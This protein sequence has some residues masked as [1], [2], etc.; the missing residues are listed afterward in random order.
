MIIWIWMINE[1]SYILPLIK[2][3]LYILFIINAKSYNGTF[4]EINHRRPPPPDL[5]T[6]TKCQDRPNE[7]P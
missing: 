2:A 4:A 1:R 3:C 5:N 6:H 7:P